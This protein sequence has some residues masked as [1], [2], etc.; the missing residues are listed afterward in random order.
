[1]AAE[2]AQEGFSCR[3]GDGDTNIC[4]KHSLSCLHHVPGQRR[5]R[6]G[7]ALEPRS[8]L[9][10][11]SGSQFSSLLYP[12]SQLLILIVFSAFPWMGMFEVG[13]E[14]GNPVLRGA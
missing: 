8:L 10:W 7:A 13:E 14:K 11:A 9:I 3:G 1:M 5:A 2:E 12:R 4:S 6:R